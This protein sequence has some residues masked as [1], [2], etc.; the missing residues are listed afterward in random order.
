MSQLLKFANNAVAVVPHDLPPGTSVIQL[1]P[2]DGALFPTTENG[3]FKLTLE[4]RRVRPV[5][6]EICNCVQRSGDTL[7]VMR[8]QEFTSAKTFANGFTASNRVTA[9]SINTLLQAAEGLG[10]LWLGVHVTP[11]TV[12]NDGGPIPMG[13]LYFNSATHTTYAW[14]GIAW[15]AQIQPGPALT[16]RLFYIATINQTLFG[17]TPDIYGQTLELNELAED[18]V[19]LYWNGE[20]RFLDDGTGTKGDYVVD[21]ANNRVV[22]RTPAVEGDHIELHQLMGRDRLAPTVTD[23]H[24]LRDINLDPVSGT[25]GYIDGVRTDFKLRDLSN[26]VVAPDDAYTV[27][28]FLD[29]VHQRPTADY[30]TVGDEVRFVE[31]PPQGTTFWGYFFGQGSGLYARIPYPSANGQILMSVDMQAVWTDRV[32][33]GVY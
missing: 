24:G 22:L 6:R 15:R 16:V 28:I 5:L 17:D 32:D 29:G 21:Y 4:D 1:S 3:Y 26:A 13:A 33:E 8:A 9:A 18:P 20:I 14:D 23:A 19:L 30:T 12:G 31:A 27:Q 10:E 11:P 7:T 2:G 25:P